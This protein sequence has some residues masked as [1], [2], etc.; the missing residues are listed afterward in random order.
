MLTSSSGRLARKSIHTTAWS[1]VALGC[2]LV[3]GILTA[4][5]LGPNDRGALAIV[6]TTAGIGTLISALGTNVALR[7]YL[8]TDPRVTLEI[9]R[10]LSA[11]LAVLCLAM[12]LPFVLFV[13]GPVE[14][15]L[16]N[17]LA[18]ACI[19][20]LVLSFFFSNQTLDCFNA[21]H[22]AASSARL[23][24]FGAFCTAIM[25]VACWVTDSSLAAALMAYVVGFSVRAV[26]GTVMLLNSA[27][28]NVLP[29][30]PGGERL[31]LTRGLPLLGAN[32]GQA[33]MMRIDQVLVGL[34]LGSGAAGIYAVAATPAGM[35]AVVSNS[36]GQVTFAE[37]AHGRAGGK[38]LIRQVLLAVAATAAAAAIG[39]ALVPWI[40]PLLFGQAFSA[41]VPIAQF[42]LVAQ[43]L[44]SPFLVLSRATAGYAMI[45][46][47][48]CTGLLGTLL[49]LGTTLILAPRFG[50]LGVTFACGVTYGA[51][52]AVAAIIVAVRQPWTAAGTLPR[53]TD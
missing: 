25:I 51:L 7:V 15:D 34:V 35:L 28:R 32:V 20:A 9:Y 2:S 39:V 53:S 6:L 13:I 4:R 38:F 41:S 37:A 31:L 46:A 21:L 8:P 30:P 43:V 11:K 14:G 19:A 5:M 47:A 40:L 3:S 42:L 23:D 33:V 16:R 52:T 27:N 10:R 45:W 44:L 17:P 18:I 22:M 49:I 26:L 50:L 1:I 29:T 36:I 48:G 24:A 12:L